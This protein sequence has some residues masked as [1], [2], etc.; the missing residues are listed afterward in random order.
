MLPDKEYITYTLVYLK[1]R[2]KECKKEYN[3]HALVINWLIG[4]RDCDVCFS[5]EVFRFLFLPLAL[6]NKAG[7][8]N[9]LPKGRKKNE[10]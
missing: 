6:D 7:I 10:L 4:V 2:K 9:G 5:G 1:S 3:L 8:L